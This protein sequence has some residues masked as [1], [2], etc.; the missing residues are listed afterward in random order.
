MPCVITVKISSVRIGSFNEFLH[1]LLAHAVALHR[2]FQ[3]EFSICM[4]EHTHH[5]GILLKHIVRASPNNNTGLFFCQFFNDLRLI[6][7]QIIIRCKTF[8]L[9]RKQFS[10][11]WLAEQAKPSGMTHLL[12]RHAEKP[13]IDATVLRCHTQDLSAVTVDSKIF[14]Q[15]GP[16]GFP[17][18]SV[19]P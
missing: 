10:L 9:R 17:S 11:I 19:L 2:A 13:F 12:I 7:K 4:D 16:D 6:V 3:T 15:H 5:I 8:V 18:A 14:R 1:L